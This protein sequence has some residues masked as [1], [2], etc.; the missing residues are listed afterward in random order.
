MKGKRLW[1][2]LGINRTIV[3]LSIVRL[4]DGIANSILFIV[5]PLYA[6]ELPDASLSLPLPL[7]VG[8]LI[9]AYG[10]AAGIQPF[11]GHW[12]TGSATTSALS[13]PD[14][15][16]P[17][18][19]GIYPF[20]QLLGF[21]GPANLARVWSCHGDSTHYGTDGHDVPA[22]NSRR[23]HGFLYHPAYAGA[24]GRSNSRRIP[25]RSFRIQ[26]SLYRRCR[27]SSYSHVHTSIRSGGCRFFQDTFSRPEESPDDRVFIHYAV[28]CQCRVCNISRS[29][30]FHI[31]HNT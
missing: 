21:I 16:W 1:E 24:F 15:L 9:S 7:I 22:G 30:R 6:A 11:T 12:S 2:F 18:Y 25:A 5:I 8:I 14:W 17:G 13:W 29:M 10:V 19:S 3:V 31:D 26:R 27:H 4:G 23:V 28:S 20:G